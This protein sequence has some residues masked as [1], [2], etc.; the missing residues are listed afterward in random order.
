LP[1]SAI[2]RYLTGM[3]SA[4][5]PLNRE[6]LKQRFDT[7]SPFRHFVIDNFLDPDFAREVADS[8]PSFEEAERLGFTFKAVNE[9]RKVQ[10]TDYDRFPAATKKLAD[11]LAAPSFMQDLE[12]VTGLRDL[13]WDG[14]FAG[15]GMHQT[16]SHGLLDVHV[17]F[18]RLESSGAYRRLNLLL[19]LNPVW[20]EEWG[21]LIEL[22]DADVKVRHQALQ[23]IMNRCVVFETSEISFHGVTAV[24]TPPG[25]TRKSFAV[26]YYTREAPPGWAGKSHSTIFKARPDEHLKKH[27]L[28]PAHAAQKQLNKGVKQAKDLIKGILGR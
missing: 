11:A 5:L 20:R 4:I 28:M 23:P 10:V 1:T 25:M 7:A 22:W 26:Y 14:G 21:G 27:V 13:C 24:T 3:S 16:D 8:Y 18:N 15:G 17:D 6:A 12:A 9:Y 19:Y 2:S